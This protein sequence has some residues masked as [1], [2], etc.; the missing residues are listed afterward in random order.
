MLLAEGPGVVPGVTARPV[1]IEDLAPTLA[2]LVG[3]TLT[4]VDGRPIP[5]ICG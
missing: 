5:E 4:G 3:V 1:A 2:R